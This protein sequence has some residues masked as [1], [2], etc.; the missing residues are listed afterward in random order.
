MPYVQL[1]EKWGLNI[2][3]V[4][5]KSTSSEHNAKSEVVYVYQSHSTQHC[6]DKHP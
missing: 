2:A 1:D 4:V 5:F 3:R 6:I